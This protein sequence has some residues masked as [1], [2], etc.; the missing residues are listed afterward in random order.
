[1]PP[2]EWR[3]AMLPNRIFRSIYLETIDLDI[4]GLLSVLQL[5]VLALV[6]QHKLPPLRRG[7]TKSQ[8]LTKSTSAIEPE[9]DLLDLAPQASGTTGTKFPSP[10]A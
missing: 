4:R 6:A 1:M 8:I 7:F 3:A 2:G 9:D 10:G 5:I